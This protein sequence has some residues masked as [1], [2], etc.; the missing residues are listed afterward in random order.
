MIIKDW[1][2][3]FSSMLYFLK[4]IFVRKDYDVTFVSSA[5]FNRGDKGENLLLKPMIS[6]CKKHK[7]KYIVFEDTD[8]KGLYDN[9]NRSSEALP[10]DFISLIQIILRKFFNLFF[11]K[12]E[13]ESELYKREYKIS[14]IIKR[15]FF[16]KFRSDVYITLLF[17]NVTLWRSINPDA[18]VVDYQHGIIFDGH[19]RY[20]KD[21]QPPMI[22]L[23]NNVV[24]MVYGDTFKNI[25][26]DNDESNFY[27][28]KNVIK[29]GLNKSN[30]PQRNLSKTNKNILFTLQITPDE[31]YKDVNENY[32]EIV[33][34]LITKNAEFLSSNNYKIILRHHP[35]FSSKHC[36]TI[37]CKYG[38]VDFDNITPI[39]ELLDSVHLHMTFNSTSAFE[40]SEIGLPTIFIG[41]FKEMSP[42][43]IFLNQYNYPLRDY[44]VK[45]YKD[46]ENI[47]NRLSKESAYNNCC[48]DVHMWS[49]DLY[50]N[51]DEI[52]FENFLLE[53]TNI[54]NSNQG[55]KTNQK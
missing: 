37:N 48:N 40:A 41:M 29:V 18:C 44:V 9:F 28:D 39:A 32:I 54:R 20:V 30:N 2:N 34:D 12:P 19:D 52:V 35:R 3:M 5:Y 38:F 43:E 6:S 55:R 21:G 36:P 51:F 53:K 22:K 16:N 45:E 49:K 46:L 11:I 4:L 50:S 14:K 8:L 27:N 24:T 7:L 13:S 42:N 25:L 1:K 10:F 47:L 26:I 23:S 33:E 31:A 15:L 17:N